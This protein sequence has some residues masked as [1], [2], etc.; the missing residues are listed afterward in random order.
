MDRRSAR[1][2]SFQTCAF[3]A[4]GRDFEA[5]VVDRAV[6]WVE[7][8]GRRL[9]QPYLDSN[10]ASGLFAET[11]E[12]LV[13]LLTQVTPTTLRA[14]HIDIF[15]RLLAGGE[16]A[17]KEE[18][19]VG[20]MS[21]MPKSAAVEEPAAA[22]EQLPLMQLEALGVSLDQLY[23][24]DGAPER[25]H[26]LRDTNCALPNLNVRA[27]KMSEVALPLCK[28]CLQK[29][30]SAQEGDAP[31]SAP[32]AAA[33]LGSPS[34]GSPSL[35]SPSLT[36]AGAVAAT[37][38]PGNLFSSPP[39]EQAELLMLHVLLQRGLALRQRAQ[40]QCAELGLS[41]EEEEALGQP[42]LGTPARRA[43]LRSLL[44]PPSSGS[45]KMVWED[46]MEESS[47]IKL[48]VHDDPLLLALR[49]PNDDHNYAAHEWSKNISAA[50]A[51]AQVD[52]AGDNNEEWRLVRWCIDV[53][54]ARS[55]YAP[56]APLSQLA[57][58]ARAQAET[59]L[60]AITQAERRSPWEATQDPDLEKSDD[61]AVAHAVGELAR[62]SE[63]LNRACSEEL[64]HQID[65]DD[66]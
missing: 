11:E 29:A 20:I 35:G 66:E 12:N 51:N 19:S 8:I 38:K 9:M 44:D 21:R 54:A 34:L 25:L 65:E 57:E 40:Q 61:D 27:P 39:R 14:F 56:Q 31:P 15:A 5:Q 17:L 62:V 1:R 16:G 59:V 24:W 52:A 28:I 26:W 7:W 53:V 3:Q 55:P 13:E 63:E 18:F 41:L 42:R 36:A 47:A 43:M 23:V 37:A 46:F 32:E 58:K 10:R 4:A 64:N 45:A 2:Q 33:S 6:S 50:E 48:D 22:E 60:E 49:R 30:E